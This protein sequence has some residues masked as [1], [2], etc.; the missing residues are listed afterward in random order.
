MRERGFALLG[1][2]RIWYIFIGWVD[3]RRVYADFLALDSVDS[4]MRHGVIRVR[5]TRILCLSFKFSG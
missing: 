1:N 4:Q 2:K 5:E 3:C